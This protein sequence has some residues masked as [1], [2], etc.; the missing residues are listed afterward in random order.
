MVKARPT[1]NKRILKIEF[2]KYTKKQGIEVHERFERV[3]KDCFRPPINPIQQ[4]HSSLTEEALQESLIVRALDQY[5]PSLS[6]KEAFE[7]RIDRKI[8]DE[9]WDIL[10]RTDE[11]YVPEEGL[12]NICLQH[13]ISIG[14]RDKKE[15]A[16]ELYDRGIILV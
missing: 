10:K 1:V 9:V 13:G 5:L 2:G 8:S 11:K 6:D 7:V 14:K 15:L 12:R 3:I 4:I 16:L